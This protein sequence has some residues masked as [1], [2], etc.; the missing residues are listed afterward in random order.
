MLFTFSLVKAVQV[1]V[2][3]K[4]HRKKLKK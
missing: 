3:E 1:C 4:K 2:C